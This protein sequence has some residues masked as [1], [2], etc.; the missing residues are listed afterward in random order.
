MP[1]ATSAQLVDVDD[2]PVAQIDL[3]DLHVVVVVAGQRLQHA[4]TCRRAAEAREHAGVTDVAHPIGRTRFASAAERVVEPVLAI[5]RADEVDVLRRRRRCARAGRRSSRSVSARFSAGVS[6]PSRSASADHPRADRRLVGVAHEREVAVRA[7]AC[8]WLISVERLRG[9]RR[10]RAPRRSSAG[11]YF[12]RWSRNMRTSAMSRWSSVWT[13]P[14]FCAGDEPI[15]GEMADVAPVSRHAGRPR[16]D[17]VA[18][19]I[20]T[21]ANSANKLRAR[22]P[23]AR[24]RRCR[25]V[26]K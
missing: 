19:V 22:L 20:D 18:T 8:R 11:E 14:S 21:G 3:R 2:R 17:P 1:A 23:A 5:E 15:V 7:R 16:L 9:R 4:R 6:Q 12:S 13:K 25:R 24:S 26:W 10:P